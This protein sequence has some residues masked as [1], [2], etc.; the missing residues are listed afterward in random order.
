MGKLKVSFTTFLFVFSFIVCVIVAV[1]L[2][3]TA[4]LIGKR[5]RIARANAS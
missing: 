3:F 5:Y 4:H 2:F 1:I